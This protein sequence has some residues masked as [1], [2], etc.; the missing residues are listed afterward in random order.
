[1]ECEHLGVGTSQPVNRANADELISVYYSS[2]SDEE[3]AE[4]T[5]WGNLALRE[6]SAES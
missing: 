5:H 1:V 2:L 3:I 4:Q 6:F